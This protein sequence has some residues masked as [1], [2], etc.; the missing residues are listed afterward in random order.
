MLRVKTRPI[1]FVVFLTVMFLSSAVSSGSDSWD[2]QTHGQENMP[3]TIN[4]L[5]ILAEHEETVHK[6]S[7]LSITSPY[8][9]T[10]FPPDI[11]APVFTWRTDSDCR[12][13]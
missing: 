2:S 6:T 13:D 1:L 5:L 7:E 4:T 12:Q 3:P 10:I 8:N 11:A 9:K